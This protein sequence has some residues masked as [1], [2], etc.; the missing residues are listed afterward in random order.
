VSSGKETRRL[1]VALAFLLPSLALFVTFVFV[2]LGRTLFLS[3][4][5]TTPTGR[6]ATFAGLDQYIELLGSTIFR[7]GLV[8]STLFALYTVP[9]GIALALVLSVLA[10]QRLRGINVF[11]TLMSSTIAISAAIGSL[12]FLLL[13]NP[14]LGLLNYILSL[15]GLRGLSWL[16]D[17]A[18]AVV[19]LS[20][21]TIWLI[22]GFNVIVLLAGLQGVPE[23]L[24]EAAKLD[25]AS[26]PRLFFGITIPLMSPFL[27]FLL[28]VDTINVL[29][30]FTQIHVL[31]RGGPV[32]A[33]RT[34]VYSLY[35][36]AFQNFQFGF[37]SAQAFVL[38]LIVLALTI[39]Q[40]RYIE[41]RVHYQ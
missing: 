40:F 18:T 5:Y 31:T 36:D 19:S 32:D 24:Y 25:G 28:V 8:A 34:I 11:R 23:E 22:L 4:H 27:F 37:A 33:T 13:Y 9:L 1:L 41:P 12:L 20:L 30:V 35:L 6:A 2:P 14:S 16:Q 21:T 29:Q 7:D 26:A 38:F 39:L 10:N 15:F 3:L 17:P